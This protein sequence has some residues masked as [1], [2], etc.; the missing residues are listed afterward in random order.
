MKREDLDLIISNLPENSVKRACYIV[1]EYQRYEEYGIFIDCAVSEEEYKEALRIILAH[2]FL[3]SNEN[4]A[5]ELWQCDG[6]CN[7]N[8]GFNEFCP[9]E[10]Q[11]CKDSDKRLCKFFADPNNL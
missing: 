3:T 9:G 1:R 2:S 8:H 10:F 4:T 6:D 7:R 5:V 11:V